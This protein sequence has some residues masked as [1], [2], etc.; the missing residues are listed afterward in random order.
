MKNFES[1]LAKHLEDSI[2]YRRELGYISKSLRT[3]LR[4]FD[5]YVR[6]NAQDWEHLNPAFFLTFRENIRGCPERVNNILL[7][8]RNFF[9]YLHRREYCSSNPVRDLP[10]KRENAFIPF[11]FS[12]EQTEQFVQAVQSQIRRT[13]GQHFLVDLGISTAILL[14]ARCGLRIS[15]PL[16]LGLDQYDSFQGTLYI[17]KT[18]YYKDRLLPLPESVRTHLDNYLN[19]RKSMKPENPYLLSGVNKGLSDTQIYPIF[20]KALRKIGIRSPRKTIGNTV[21]GSPTP[22]CLRHSFAVNTLKAAK[23]RGRDPQAVLPVLAAY[24]GHRQYRYTALYLKVL[25][26]QQRQGFVDFALSRLEYL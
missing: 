26:A 12:P 13:T 4:V 1:F 3:Q 18:K 19:V 20:H 24:M 5:Q 11:I 7:T 8:V 10:A 17:R 25:D 15:E 16:K 6:D 21:F 22:H 14:Q 9:D 23:D 2:Q